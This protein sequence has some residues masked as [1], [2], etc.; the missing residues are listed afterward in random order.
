MH[1]N[2]DDLTKGVML[3]HRNMIANALQMKY[4]EITSSN[5]LNWKTDKSIGFL[6]LY[7]IYGTSIQPI[8]NTLHY[9]DYVI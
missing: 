7:H 8:I 5:A 9:A 2:T 6:P 4:S 3:T 1:Q